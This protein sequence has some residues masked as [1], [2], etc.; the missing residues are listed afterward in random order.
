MFICI[1]NTYLHILLNLAIFFYSKKVE[2]IVNILCEKETM[3]IE[4]C[5][6]SC[7]FNLNFGCVL[8]AA[9]V[10]VVAVLIYVRLATYKNDWFWWPIWWKP[11][12]YLA[13][14]FMWT[15]CWFGKYHTK[16]TFKNHNHWSILNIKQK[17][18]MQFSTYA[19]C[20]L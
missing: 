3:L 8:S 20:K 1:W 15:F 18:A 10:F 12:F 14:W 5:D 13:G 6:K 9:D 11:H 16:N 7:V 19:L 4:I 17:R 2:N